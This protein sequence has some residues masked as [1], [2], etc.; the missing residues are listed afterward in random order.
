MSNSVLNNHL[1]ELLI[2]FFHL[3]KTAAEV[4]RELHKV[5]GD[6]ALSK[7]T[8]SDWFR[9]FKDGDFDVDDRP[10]EGRPKTVEDC[11][12]ET[13]PDKDPCQTQQEHPSALG[14]QSSQDAVREKTRLMHYVGGHYGTATAIGTNYNSMHFHSNTEHNTNTANATT[15]PPSTTSVLRSWRKK[16]ASEKQP[17][18]PNV[19]EQSNAAS[20]ES[21]GPVARVAPHNRYPK[22]PSAVPPPPSDIFRYQQQYGDFS[23]QNPAQ[24]ATPV[25]YSEIIEPMQAIDP[26]P[27]IHLQKPKEKT[28]MEMCSVQQGHMKPYHQDYQ[29]YKQHYDGLKNYNHMSGYKQ[30]YHP[31]PYLPKES[32]PLGGYPVQK[33]PSIPHHASAQYLHNYKTSPPANYPRNY[34]RETGNEFL[35]N[36]NKIAPDMAQDII[37]DP[38]LRDPHL[39]E[40]QYPMYP[41]S[42]DQNRMYQQQH[43]QRIYQRTS[44]IQH[45]PQNYPQ[46]NIQ[47][48]FNQYQ[49]NQQRLPPPDHFRMFPPHQRYGQVEQIPSNISPRQYHENI[50]GFQP[51]I[52]PNYP[53]CNQMEY[54]QHYQHRQVPMRQDFL[55]MP[56]NKGYNIEA[57][58]EIPEIVPEDSLHQPKKTLKAFLENWREEFTEDVDS[59]DPTNSEKIQLVKSAVGNRENTLYVLD[60]MEIPSENIPQYLHLQHIEKLPPNIRTF[61]YNPNEENLRQNAV[62][63]STNLKPEEL[64]DTTLS[65]KDETNTYQLFQNPKDEK[66]QENLMYQPNLSL[67]P[68][69]T[70]DISS[71]E[72]RPACKLLQSMANARNANLSDKPIEKPEFSLIAQEKKPMT[73]DEAENNICRSLPELITEDGEDIG[74]NQ[75][76]LENEYSKIV[77]SILEENINSKILPEKV[78]SVKLHQSDTHQN[79]NLNFPDADLMKNFEIAERKS[80]IAENTAPA[81]QLQADIDAKDIHQE[82]SEILNG[83]KLSEIHDQK[84]ENDRSSPRVEQD[85]SSSIQSLPGLEDPIDLSHHFENLQ[86]IKNE[87]KP[88]LPAEIET[89]KDQ[90]DFNDGQEMKHVYTDILSFK[91]VLN[92]TRQHNEAILEEDPEKNENTIENRIKDE[93]ICEESQDANEETE[94]N[95]AVTSIIEKQNPEDDL[96]DGDAVN[97]NNKFENHEPE[98]CNRNSDSIDEDLTNQIHDKEAA[99]ELSNENVTLVDKEEIFK[100]DMQTIAKEVVENEPSHQMVEKM[101]EETSPILEE[102]EIFKGNENAIDQKEKSEERQS[103]NEENFETNS[104]EG[105]AEEKNEE[106]ICQFNVIGENLV[107]L[108]IM[109]VND[110]NSEPEEFM[111]EMINLENEEGSKDIDANPSNDDGNQM[112]EE[113][114][115][116]TLPVEDKEE[117]HEEIDETT[118][119]KGTSP[120]VLDSPKEQEQIPQDDPEPITEITLDEGRE[121]I[122]TDEENTPPVNAEIIKEN[123]NEDMEEAKEILTEEDPE[124][125]ED[126][127]EETICDEDVIIEANNNNIIAVKDDQNLASK[128]DDIGSSFV[129]EIAKELLQICVSEDNNGEKIISVTPLTNVKVVTTQTEVIQTVEDKDEDQEVFNEEIGKGNMDIDEEKVEENK[130]IPSPEEVQEISTIEEEI[131]IEELISEVTIEDNPIE[132]LTEQVEEIPVDVHESNGETLTEILENKDEIIVENSDPIKEIFPE[133]RTIEQ[134]IPED[135]HILIETELFLDNEIIIENKDESMNELAIPLDNVENASFILQKYDEIIEEETVES[136]Q[137]EMIINNNYIEHLSCVELIREEPKSAEEK[138]KFLQRKTSLKKHHFRNLKVKTAISSLDNRK[139]HR[140]GVKKKKRVKFDLANLKKSD[141]LANLAEKAKIFS[142]VVVIDKLPLESIAK[143]SSKPPNSCKKPVNNVGNRKIL[144]TPISN[145]KYKELKMKYKKKMENT[146]EKKMKKIRGHPKTT[147]HAEKIE[148]PKVEN[149]CNETEKGVVEKENSDMMVVNDDDNLVKGEVPSNTKDDPIKSA[150]KVSESKLDEIPLPMEN[151]ED[152]NKGATPA[153]VP[154]NSECQNQ[155][156]QRS[157]CQNQEIKSSECQNQ[158]TKTRDDINLSNFERPKQID[159]PKTEISLIPNVSM[160]PIS[161]FHIPKSTSRKSPV[162]SH[163]NDTPKAFCGS[164]PPI[165]ETPKRAADPRQIPSSSKTTTTPEPKP[166]I[167]RSIL[168]KSPPSHYQKPNEPEIFSG[169]NT[170]TTSDR[171]FQV[172]NDVLKHSHRFDN[173]NLRYCPK[174]YKDLRRTKSESHFESELLA[175]FKRRRLS[176]EEYN[177]RRRKKNCGNGENSQT[178]H[179]GDPGNVV[180]DTE[181]I[182]VEEVLKSLESEQIELEERNGIKMEDRKP[183]D[184]EVCEIKDI[185]CNLVTDKE[186]LDKPVKLEDE[187]GEER[188][189]DQSISKTVDAASASIVENVQISEEKPVDFKQEE[190]STETQPED[191]PNAPTSISNQTKLNP[192]EVIDKSKEQHIDKSTLEEKLNSL[193]EFLPK[194][195]PKETPSP[196]YVEETQ[197]SKKL[198][199]ALTE[200]PIPYSQKCNEMALIRRFLNHENLTTEELKKISQIVQYKRAIESLKKQSNN[201]GAE[202]EPKRRYSSEFPKSI[203]IDF[204]DF[205]MRKLESPSPNTP[206]R[207]DKLCVSGRIC[208]NRSISAFIEEESRRRKV[209]TRTKINLEALG[210]TPIDTL[211]NSPKLK[212]S[213]STPRIEY[214]DEDSDNG[215]TMKFTASPKVI[216]EKSES[217]SKNKEKIPPQNTKTIQGNTDDDDVPSTKSIIKIENTENNQVTDKEKEAKEENDPFAVKIKHSIMNII[218]AKPESCNHSKALKHGIENIIEIKKSDDKD[219]TTCQNIGDPMVEKDLANI[220]LEAQAIPIKKED[221]YSPIHKASNSKDLQLNQDLPTGV[222]EGVSKSQN[223]QQE[224]KDDQKTFEG[225]SKTR[226]KPEDSPNR[227]PSSTAGLEKLPKLIRIDKMNFEQRPELKKNVPKVFENRNKMVGIKRIDFQP[228]RDPIKPFDR[229]MMIKSVTTSLIGDDLF[230]GK[231]N[232]QK[233]VKTKDQISVQNLTIEESKVA[234]IRSS[235]QN[236]T[237]TNSKTVQIDQNKTPKSSK[238]K[239]DTPKCTKMKTQD[240]DSTP[241]ARKLSNTDEPKHSKNKLSPSQDISNSLKPVSKTKAQLKSFQDAKEQQNVSPV[242]S[243]ITKLTALLTYYKKGIENGVENANLKKIEEIIDRLS[244][245]LKNLPNLPEAGTTNECDVQKSDKEHRKQKQHLKRKSQN[246]NKKRKRR[247]RNLY[248]GNDSD[249]DGNLAPK[250]KEAKLD[251]TDYSV[252]QRKNLAGVPK[253]ILKRRKSDVRNNPQP[254]VKISRI[255]SIENMVKRRKR[256]IMLNQVDIDD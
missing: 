202:T 115:H 71:H 183:A 248:T 51:R 232:D 163:Q 168:K 177:N 26:I 127:I 223:V 207:E 87:S 72:D 148:I 240:Q 98:E 90:D 6:A 150:T 149:G 82:E 15:G 172:P 241:E 38:H 84:R 169:P 131:H 76:N 222:E 225:I 228:M 81:P 137:E 134:E 216:R 40:A 105:I 48:N 189:P 63:I 249:E 122:V 88:E 20:S 161:K 196:R 43:H 212:T 206:N 110:H 65:S 197:I 142:S 28:Y 27:P 111:E 184:V 85:T 30:Q 167:L 128:E 12:L 239:V 32:Q 5:Y 182:L 52:S 103:L 61:A 57:H 173:L 219:V 200:N 69:K 11:E 7:T 218:A 56:P 151:L 186:I 41:P 33:D 210:K 93:I 59:S 224:T 179:S 102:I 141:P 199:E 162:T 53:P 25:K 24:L 68:F 73:F 1:Q 147:S 139:R 118:V 209:E 158:E 124:I 104:L 39:R 123:E 187:L 114:E 75:D 160:S 185:E 175:N 214:L 29:N 165:P 9:R 164:K 89:N 181:K 152:K 44:P 21:Q 79:T 237:P 14:D 130:E 74:R 235:N 140:R 252:Y 159:Q 23:V 78:D 64:S 220:A 58:P 166:Q 99:T 17:T 136:H 117:I 143:F 157:E 221:N 215:V 70:S 119:E 13:L 244:P 47:Q 170:P 113:I 106:T 19:S 4:H 236:N 42:I 229:E 231:S 50:M 255:G 211:G 86:P 201:T 125:L 60:A 107:E 226:L 145:V 213:V 193:Q 77:D 112:L 108:S 243:N 242:I 135:D 153:E 174:N 109:D 238:T 194:I 144:K 36:L 188:I 146:K 35:A 92:L 208:Y 234:K 129:L 16:D 204:N 18:A 154:I 191:T 3:K 254:Y 116:L 97:L 8:C 62:V 217:S 138:L 156:I 230:K 67:N 198:E 251:G 120:P 227:R 2:F 180:K 178:N 91:D 46:R 95:I 253:L 55:P 121:C 246:E 34:P 245:N 66:T 37:N 100:E 49:M 80:V 256:S 192:N 203:K 250:T 96:K 94:E 31:H 190:N 155:E 133:N 10:R 205:E 126:N 83:V 54:P 195:S 247:F 45:P 176:L 22:P 132:S 101:D 233:L 171:H